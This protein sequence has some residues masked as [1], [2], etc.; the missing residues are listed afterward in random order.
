MPAVVGS[1]GKFAADADKLM[2]LDS[3]ISLAVLPV[4]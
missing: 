4:L 1:W 2:V 3:D